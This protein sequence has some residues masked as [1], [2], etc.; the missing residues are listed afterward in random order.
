MMKRTS[1]RLTDGFVAYPP[2]GFLE[3]IGLGV[4]P[5]VA[6][7]GHGMKLSGLGDLSQR[8]TELPGNGLVAP[9]AEEDLKDPE[10]HQGLA[11]QV[12]G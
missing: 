9:I 5:L 6:Q 3:F 11:L 12:E 7:I 8:L 2:G 4:G 10:P 1:P